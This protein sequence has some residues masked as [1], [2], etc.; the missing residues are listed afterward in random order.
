[1]HL[2][3]PAL[4]FFC[5]CTLRLACLLLE[6][7]SDGCDLRGFISPLQKGS[8]GK[9]FPPVGSIVKDFCIIYHPPGYWTAPRSDKAAPLQENGF[10]LQWISD[11]NDEKGGCGQGGGEGGW[12]QKEDTPTQL[13]TQN[14]LIF[15]TP[16]RVR[17]HLPSEAEPPASP[18]GLIRAGLYIPDVHRSVTFFKRRGRIARL[19]L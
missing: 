15:L 16:A 14:Q 3:F 9:H 8:Y 5:Q 19:K 13:Q 12:R 11:K 1:M 10:L 6:R 4:L 2:F 17:Y 18:P 7:S